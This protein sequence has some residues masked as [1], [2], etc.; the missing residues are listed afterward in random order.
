MTQAKAKSMTFAEYLDHD[1]GSDTRYDLL[2]NGELIEVPNEAWINNLLVKLLTAKLESFVDPTLI[3]AH[4]LTMQVNPVGDN[5]QSRHPDLVI[6]RAEHLTLQNLLNKTAL[7]IGDPSPQFIAEIVSPGSPSSNN[8]RR[9]YEW[10]RQQYQ[11]WGIP[12]YWVI[13]PHRAQVA[14]LTL[15]NGTY[16]EKTY[17][18]QQTIESS[19][20]PALAITAQTVLNK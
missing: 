11:D 17:T 7:L 12:E 15:I 13:D 6:L 4:V 3:V 19:I 1:D 5:R 2:S 10:K 18:G 9:D 20:F 14:V 16:Q 8:Y